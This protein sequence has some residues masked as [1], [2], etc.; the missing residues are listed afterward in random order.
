MSRITVVLYISPPA[1]LYTWSI[2]ISYNYNIGNFIHLEY[3]HFYKFSTT[4]FCILAFPIFWYTYPVRIIYILRTDLIVYCRFDILLYFRI[5]C[6]LGISGKLIWYSLMAPKV[7]PILNKQKE[8][9]A[10]KLLLQFSPDLGLKQVKTTLILYIV[11]RF[12]SLCLKLFG[13]P[14]FFKIKKVTSFLGQFLIKFKEM[15]KLSYKILMIFEIW[16]VYTSLIGW[17]PKIV[18]VFIIFR[19]FSKLFKKFRGCYNFLKIFEFL[20]KISAIFENF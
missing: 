20:T 3:W 15:P 4:H 13:I 12:F 7:Y 8:Q 19:K 17:F 1:I 5:S 16:S 6:H 14:L 9:Y 2:Y 11:T 18:K 10:R